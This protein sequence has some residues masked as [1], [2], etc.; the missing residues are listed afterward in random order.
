MKAILEFDLTNPDDVKA[1]L[2]AVKS[3]SLA[4]AIWEIDYNFKK[5]LERQIELWGDK[6]TP[7]MIINTFFNEFYSLMEEN[8]IKIDELVD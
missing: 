5:K 7:E 6:C 1:H 3:L 2:R 4:I 8:N